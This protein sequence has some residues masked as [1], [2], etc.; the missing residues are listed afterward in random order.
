[1]QKLNYLF[2]LGSEE[3]PTSAMLNLSHALEKNI[4]ANLT[5]QSLHFSQIESFVSPRR[6]AVIVSNLDAK[7]PSK[8]VERRGPSKSAAYDKNGTPKLACLGFAN[9]CGVSTDEIKIK[10]TDKGAWVYCEINQQGQYTKQLLPEIISTAIQQLPLPK[11]M[12]WGNHDFKFIRPVHWIT[13][14]LGEEIVELNLFN[15]KSQQQ[16]Y[17]HRFMHSKAIALNDPSDYYERLLQHGKVMPSFPK[18]RQYIAD[19]IKIAATKLGAKAILKASLLDEVTTLVEWPVI[20]TG[21]FSIDHLK[22]P[23][24]A[25]ISAMQNHQKCFAVVD[26]NNKLQPYFILVS[27][28][29]SKDPSAIIKGNKRVINARLNDA[30]F[31][32]YQDLKKSLSSHLSQLEHVIFQKDL[33][34]LANKS[35]RISTLSKFIAQ[36]IVVDQQQA[37]RAGLICKCDLLSAMVYE[38]PELQGIM[39]Y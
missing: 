31:F 17:G 16:T 24:E 29:E 36:K 26:D 25:L 30:A 27:N 23:Q 8:I 10:E 2:E 19:Q 32:Y 38:F 33:G 3:L 14:L 21:S 5:Q 9:S 13:S 22:I 15:L 18:R 1:M 28:I 12:R 34:S 39:G 20:L 11:P 35:E 37:A 7:Q 4:E 6:L